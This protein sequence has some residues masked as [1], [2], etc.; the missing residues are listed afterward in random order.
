MQSNDIK[1]NVILRGPIFAEPVKVITT[2]PMGDSIKI[3]G[4][5]MQTGKV[6]QPIL[7][8]DQ[9]AQLEF[10]SNKKPYDGDPQKFRLGIEALRLALAY[11]CH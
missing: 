9:I 5:G 8:E 7:K 3:V 6:H 10:S 11:P 4:E 2:I 1:P